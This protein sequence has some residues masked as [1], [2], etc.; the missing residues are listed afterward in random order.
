MTVCKDT[1][2][3]CTVRV[4]SWNTNGTRKITSLFL[5]LLNTTV[6]VKVNLP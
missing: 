1:I 6:K 2:H 3:I 4:F 5:S